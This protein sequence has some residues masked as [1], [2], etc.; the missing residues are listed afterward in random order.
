MKIAFMDRHGVLRNGGPEEQR[1]HYQFG[2]YVWITACYCPLCDGVVDIV[3]EEPF[4]TKKFKG[5]KKVLERKE[6]L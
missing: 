4:E 6:R 5:I 2:K 1:S 3:S